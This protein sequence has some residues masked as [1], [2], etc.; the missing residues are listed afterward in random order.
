MEVRRTERGWAGH[1]IAAR[2][3]MFRRN[4]LLEYG[5]MKLVVSTVGTMI[6][7]LSCKLEQIGPDRYYETMVFEVDYDD[8][9]YDADVKKNIA[10]RGE[11]QLC[12][13][14]FDDLLV[15]HPYPDMDA[16]DMHENVVYEMTER[17]KKGTVYDD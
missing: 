13:E 10:I 9:Y 1:Y 16:N 3:C 2:H 4:T 15:E 14:T 17:L 8:P 7:P 11:W 6:D 5:D 12:A